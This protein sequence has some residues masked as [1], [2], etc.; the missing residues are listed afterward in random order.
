MYQ[1]FENK[2]KRGILLETTYLFENCVSILQEYQKIISRKF[3]HAILKNPQ[4]GHGNKNSYAN[5]DFT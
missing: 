3:K 1:S 4:N 2:E 5:S